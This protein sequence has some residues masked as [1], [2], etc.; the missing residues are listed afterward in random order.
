M[1]KIL[2]LSVFGLVLCAMMFAQTPGRIITQELLLR[3]GDIMNVVTN[4]GTTHSPHFHLRALL[5]ETGVERG[6]DLG[7]VVGAMRISSG[8]G[9][10]WAS[11]NQSIWPAVWPAGSTVRIRIW[12]RG[13][14]PG[15]PILGPGDGVDP[16]PTMQYAQ[17]DIIVPPGGGA[18]TLFDGGLEMIVPPWPPTIGITSVPAGANVLVNGA[19]LNP[20][21][22]TPFVLAR[23]FGWSGSVS[24]ALP[25][26]TWD[27][28]SVSVVN[29][30]DHMTAHFVGTLPPAEHTI[31][32]TSAPPGVPI[33]VDGLPLAP[34][35][36]T[37]YNLVKPAG[38]SGTISVHWPGYTWTP[39]SVNV[40]NLAADMPAHFVGTPT[41][42]NP[43]PAILV[44]P[45]DGEV[46]VWPW[47]A[48]DQEI[49]LDWDPD[50]AGAM[51]EGYLV[52][53]QDMV[54]PVAN[55]GA[56]ITHWM[57]PVL[58]EGSY[59]WRIVPYIVDP[60][61]P[62]V[63]RMLAPVRATANVR[64]K[65]PGAV[66][67]PAV[68]SPIWTFQIDR[69]PPPPVY[70]YP[71]G[72][73]VEVGIGI[74]QTIF[75]GDADIVDDPVNPF[76]PFPNPAGEPIFQTVLRL[77]GAGPWT[78]VYNTDAALGIWYSYVTNSWTI[79][80]NDGGQIIFVIPAGGKN[81]PEVPIALGDQALPVVMS[82]FTA[83][84]TAQN[85]VALTWVT[86][87]E[88]GLSGY[89]VYRAETNNFTNSMMITPT[90]IPAHNTSTQQVYR[91]EDHDVTVGTTYYYWLE[92]VEFNGATMFGPVSVTVEGDGG[93]I[94]PPLPEV[95]ILRNAYPNPF[96]IAGNTTIEVAVKAGENGT[97]T[98][99]NILGQA[100][101]TFTVTEGNHSIIWNG[102]DSK[103][104]ICGSGIYF[105][106]LST[107][108]MSQTKKLVIVK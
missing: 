30:N 53:F 16:Y 19:P 63:K 55:L 101:K 47:N 20:P 83:Q 10:A 97:V 93:S 98:I 21:R 22:V 80:H 13:T 72:E 91:L 4:T 87:S 42:I 81:V 102:R 2:L 104:K 75:G 40:V 107:P 27:P 52:F 65:G 12:Y 68:G 100:V 60:V 50:S 58:G 41:I 9:Q 103:G 85:F 71:E 56:D 108:S 51:P 5:V 59:S 3:E 106:R 37:P 79:V 29:L 92:A 86:Q 48:P 31:S 32:I 25:G 26:Y 61:P 23:P 84:L 62:G 78:I 33:R 8:A 70:D 96:D 82:R 88:S 6:T 77:Y 64:A 38:W 44:G 15:F 45:G 69:L 36:V 18:I 94:T 34:P 89:R 76:P 14:A 105:Y 49:L 39:P 99:Y 67:G 73:T 66:K 7:A 17:K 24:V 1:K 35:Q 28:P 43:L 57:T 11:I 46:I 74:L 95:T 54:V 90:M